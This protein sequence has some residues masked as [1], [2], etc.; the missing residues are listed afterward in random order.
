MHRC[1]GCNR[2]CPP[3]A[4][5]HGSR[6]PILR[7]WWTHVMMMISRTQSR[8]SRGSE[9]EVCILFLVQVP[10]ISN[11]TCG[12]QKVAFLPFLASAIPQSSIGAPKRIPPLQVLSGC[13]MTPSQRPRW[14]CNSKSGAG[15]LRVPSSRGLPQHLEP[16]A[17][18]RFRCPFVA[19]G[20]QARQV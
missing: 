9:T 11:I 20:R 12:L 3:D 14:R 2:L 7:H 13:C 4:G 6:D 5:D 8:Q 16:H 15:V 10:G 19:A 17:P 18:S 1:L